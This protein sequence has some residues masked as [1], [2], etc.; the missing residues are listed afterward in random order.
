M[1]SLPVTGRTF[2]AGYM[3]VKVTVRPKKV[4]FVIAAPAELY[5]MAVVVFLIICM[6]ESVETMDYEIVHCCA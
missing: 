4:A 6:R 3:Q 2:V 5:R 1:L